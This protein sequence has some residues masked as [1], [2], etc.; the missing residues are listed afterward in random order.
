MSLCI[1]T[2]RRSIYVTCSITRVVL[3]R[4]HALASISF[5]N[6]A[7]EAFSLLCYSQ[8]TTTSR[9]QSK[10]ID[11]T[12]DSE[13][14]D[15]ATPTVI[16]SNC[17]S[18]RGTNESSD[19]DDSDSDTDDHRSS[20]ILIPPPTNSH[21][22]VLEE[23]EDRTLEEYVIQQPPGSLSAFELTS[24]NSSVLQLQDPSRHRPRRNSK[25]QTHRHSS[26]IRQPSSRGKL[27][28]QTLAHGVQF[29][30]VPS[31]RPPTTKR[32]EFSSQNLLACLL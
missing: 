6:L 2:R 23:L 20:S 11:L 25:T 16:G 28:G 1:V 29:V 22:N 3:R 14:D 26:S 17:D 18:H 7:K 24:L 30:A 31:R 19:E 8:P 12:G 9:T 15:K 5:S 13:S 32:E 4:E 21:V 10:V 27:A